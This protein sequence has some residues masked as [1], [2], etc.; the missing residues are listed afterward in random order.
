MRRFSFAARPY[1]CEGAVPFASAEEAWFWFTRCQ[2]AR[3]DGAR[4]RADFALEPRPCDPDD[5]YRMVVGLARA[6][7]LRGH[8]LRVLESYGLRES[9]PDPRADEE[10]RDC[11]LWDEALDRLHTVFKA[12]GVVR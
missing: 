3:H 10:L 9:A 4:L 12:K 5:V 1:S 6:R 2:K 11:R 7:R 8:H